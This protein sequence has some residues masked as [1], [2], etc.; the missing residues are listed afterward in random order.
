MRNVSEVH[1]GKSQ[2]ASSGLRFKKLQS[3]QFVTA[4]R[5]WF[6]SRFTCQE[7]VDCLFAEV[8]ELIILDFEFPAGQAEQQGQ[9]LI[10]CGSQSRR[11]SDTQLIQ[12]L[13][14]FPTSDITQTQSKLTQNMS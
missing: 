5:S 4:T 2:F 6:C 7:F 13:N 14:S 10:R 9:E 12:C 3:R 1:L 11:L 8:E